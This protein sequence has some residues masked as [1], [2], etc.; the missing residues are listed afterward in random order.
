MSTP[1]HH[2]PQHQACCSEHQCQA[3]PCGP[4]LMLA[5]HQAVSCAPGHQS[6]TVPGHSTWPRFQAG[7]HGPGF[8]LALG[9]PASITA[10]QGTRFLGCSVLGHHMQ[11]GLRLQALSGTR[12]ALVPDLPTRIQASAPIPPSHSSCL[13]LG[14]QIP[15]LP[16]VE[17]STRQTLTGSGPNPSLGKQVLGLP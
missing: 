5:Q 11:H 6:A 2:R 1:L 15:G 9:T 13:P 4:T 7:I 3:S 16:L 14:A 12:L 10:L 8:I 17:P